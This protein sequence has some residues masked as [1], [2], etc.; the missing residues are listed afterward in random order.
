MD[1]VQ[2]LSCN[3]RAT[4]ISGVVGTTWEVLVDT[5]MPTLL[6][7]YKADNHDCNGE[8]QKACEDTIKLHLCKF[9]RDFQYGAVFNEGEDLWQLNSPGTIYAKC[10]AVL[11]KHE[12]SEECG[13]W[14]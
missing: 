9:N 2:C 14:N 3:Y 5:V 11:K 13:D 7:E 12:G 4:E 10:L 6:K 8:R 1:R